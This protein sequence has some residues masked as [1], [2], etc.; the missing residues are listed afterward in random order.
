MNGG[1]TTPHELRH[2]MPIL[3]NH[4][5]E[6]FARGLANGLTADATYG[7]FKHSDKSGSVQF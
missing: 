4:K 2:L 5:H 7:T 3:P 6:L 1:N